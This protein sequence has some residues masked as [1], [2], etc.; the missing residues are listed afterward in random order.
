[1][2][3]P[4]ARLGK[5]KSIS[6]SAR[7]GTTFERIPPRI[8]PTFTVTFRPRSVNPAAARAWRAASTI[9]L[10]PRSKSAPAWAARPSARSSMDPEPLRDVLTAPP[11]HAGSKSRTAAAELICD[12]IWAR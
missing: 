12:S 1:M 9:A 8:T 5:R 4:S 3:C 2:R 11:G 10:A 6:T 7:S